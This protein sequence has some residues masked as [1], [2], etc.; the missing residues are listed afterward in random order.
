[1]PPSDVQQFTHWLHV[2]PHTYPIRTILGKF[3]CR[4]PQAD[5]VEEAYPWLARK[6]CHRGLTCRRPGTQH[7][8]LMGHAPRPMTIRRT[9]ASWNHTYIVL[10]LLEQAHSVATTSR[11]PPSSVLSYDMCASQPRRASWQRTPQFA[12]DLHTYRDMARCSRTAITELGICPYT[13]RT[14]AV[15]TAACISHVWQ[16]FQPAQRLDAQ[17]LRLV[18]VANGNMVTAE[19]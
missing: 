12:A 2:P 5:S 4:S 3:T 9:I 19:R 15:A 16:Q 17:N 11:A 7:E 6:I 14:K 8:L 13:T 18:S 1:M 10:K